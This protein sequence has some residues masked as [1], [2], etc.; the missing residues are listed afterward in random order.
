MLTHTQSNP[1]RPFIIYH[2]RHPS[3]KKTCLTFFPFF[4]LPFLFSLFLYIKIPFFLMI[5][6]VLFYEK[7]LQ[8]VSAKVMWQ[9]EECLASWVAPRALWKT[10]NNCPYFFSCASCTVWGFRKESLSTYSC[11]DQCSN[12]GRKKKPNQ[13]KINTICAC[14]L[15][16]KDHFFVVVF[17][18]FIL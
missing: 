3:L 18:A 17:I 1:Q 6:T 2:L 11:W 9:K 13:V 7:W 4:L 5:I 15:L 8:L 14:F 16:L 10:G 12:G